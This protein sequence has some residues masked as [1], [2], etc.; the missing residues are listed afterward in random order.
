M[1]PHG[2]YGIKFGDLANG[3]QVRGRAIVATTKSTKEGPMLKVALLARLEAKAGR[4]LEVAAFLDSALALANQEA[5]TP[6]WFALRF[7]PTTFGV[8]D[9]FA[10]DAGRN[11][12][13]NG[14]IA[15]ALMAKAPELFAKPPAIER[16][17]VLGA[18]LP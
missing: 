15:Q 17:E 11:G 12:H 10:D 16:V 3:A 13:L 6:V 2:K 5:A 18:K 8:F 7:G 14:P 4:E 9:A 1:N